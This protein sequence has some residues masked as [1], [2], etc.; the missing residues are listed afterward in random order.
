MK[1]APSA[2]GSLAKPVRSGL[3]R[4]EHEVGQQRRLADE[5]ERLLAAARDLAGVLAR[6]DGHGRVS[7]KPVKRPSG[8]TRRPAREPRGANKAAILQALEGG[9]PMTA[10][11]LAKATGI[12]APTVSTSLSKMA[13]DGELE[14]AP[15]GYR[16]P[17]ARPGLDG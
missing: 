4:I 11:E 15:R 8:G 2:L 10:S 9:G 16:L 13:R 12:P 5:L 14:K 6:L 7:A 3:K 1:K 17:A